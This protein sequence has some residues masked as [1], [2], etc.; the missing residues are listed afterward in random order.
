MPHADVPDLL[1]AYDYYV[2]PERKTPTQGVAMCEAMACGLP[3]VAVRAG[4]VPEYARSG[5]DGYLVDRDD[6]GALRAAVERL[7]GDPDRAREMG[8]RARERVAA[9]CAAA[10]VIGRELELLREVAA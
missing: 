7:V 5:T 2:S 1:R 10:G 3:V 9:T 6:P 8:A 4:G